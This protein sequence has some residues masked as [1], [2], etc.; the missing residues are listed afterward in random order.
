MKYLL[1]H[2]QFA[3]GAPELNARLGLELV[4]V[5]SGP[6]G[7]ILVNRRAKPRVRLEGAPGS[8]LLVGR[9]ATRWTM[10]TESPAPSRLVVANPMFPGWRAKV[11][12]APSSIESKAGDLTQIPV[13]AGTHEV[14]LEY[15]PSSFRLS[16]A[17]AFLGAVFAVAAA[18]SLRSA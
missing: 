15:R 10:R 2:P 3:F 12:G 11:D 5:Y 18:R 17:V 1:L 7:R 6:D 8:A 16:L 9:T 13:P 4:E 14:V